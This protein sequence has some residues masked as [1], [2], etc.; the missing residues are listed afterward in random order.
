MRGWVA[1]I[2]TLAVLGTLV[3]IMRPGATAPLTREECVE[4][5]NAENDVASRAEAAAVDTRVFVDGV[6][7][8]GNHEACRYVVAPSEG[9]WFGWWA[10]RLLASGKPYE[11]ERFEFLPKDPRGRWADPDARLE[12]DGRLSLNS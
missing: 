2:L 11:W 6:L 1:S 9:E 7:E 3:W 5:W 4:L 12:V 8:P 10:S